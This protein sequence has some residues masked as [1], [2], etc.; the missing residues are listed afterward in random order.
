MKFQYDDGGRAAAGFTGKAGD[1]VT[2]A[3][4]IATGQPYAAVYAVLA[5]NAGRERNSRGAT[6]RNGIH[7]SR[8]WFKNYMR[9]L[10]WEF[11]ATM[12]IGTGCTVHLRAEELP[13]GRLVVSVSRHYCAVIDGVIHDAFD[14]QRG[15]LRCVYGYWRKAVA[16]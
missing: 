5:L 16:A 9:A 14:P 13:P 12:G 4:A 3:V 11:V 10:G 2:R 15:G 7:T 1:C 8:K 6:A